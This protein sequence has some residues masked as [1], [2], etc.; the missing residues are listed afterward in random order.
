MLDFVIRANKNIYLQTLLEECKYEIKKHK[1]ENLNDD[2]EQRSS[3]E[4]HSESDSESDNGSGND[5]SSD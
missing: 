1:M 5:E 4:S 2:L 3:N